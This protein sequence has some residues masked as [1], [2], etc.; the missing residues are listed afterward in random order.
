MTISVILVRR[1]GQT[2]TLIGLDLI[3]ACHGESTALDV[4]RPIYRG[5]H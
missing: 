5:K 4:E 2:Q 3:R 1:I